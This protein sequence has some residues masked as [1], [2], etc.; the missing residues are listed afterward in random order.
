MPI[1][2]LKDILESHNLEQEKIFARF[3]NSVLGI[4]MM[5]FVRKYL[6]TQTSKPQVDDFIRQS[7]VQL[8]LYGISDSFKSKL[9]NLATLICK[10]NITLCCVWPGLE[11]MKSSRPNIQTEIQQITDF[12][13]FEKN[14]RWAVSMD[15]L[16]QQ[17]DAL[18]M[19]Y[20]SSESGKEDATKSNNEKIQ[21]IRAPYTA[22]AQLAYLKFSNVIDHVFSSSDFLLFGDEVITNLDVI[23]ETLVDRSS[24]KIFIKNDNDLRKVVD[25]MQSKNDGSSPITFISRD[26]IMSKLEIDLASLRILFLCLGCEYLPTLPLFSSDFSS[27]KIIN[28]L[29]DSEFSLEK[30]RNSMD[31]HYSKNSNLVSQYI[32]DL[33]AGIVYTAM[34]PVMGVDGKL[35]VYLISEKFDDSSKKNKK[36]VKMEIENLPEDFGSIFGQRKS[37]IWYEELFAERITPLV[38]EAALKKKFTPALCKV[39]GGQEEITKTPEKDKKKS[40]QENNSNQKKADGTYQD[41]QVESEQKKSDKKKLDRILPITTVK[42]NSEDISTSSSTESA[43][44]KP[45]ESEIISKNK[46][47]LLIRCARKKFFR[48]DVIVKLLLLYENLKYDSIRE[49]CPIRTNIKEH[50]FDEA[51]NLLNAPYEKL[52]DEKECF[53]FIMNEK[54]KLLKH[55]SVLLRLTNKIGPHIQHDSNYFVTIPLQNI[56]YATRI[57]RDHKIVEYFR[58][59]LRVLDGRGLSLDELEKRLKR[60]TT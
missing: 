47:K 26:N 31:L 52:F 35:G 48:G 29:K 5:W 3:A 37:D 4:D 10:H 46:Q 15:H 43:H 21:I 50:E 25:L 1:R 59:V 12:N 42:F 57:G 33:K 2:G 45:I 53:D 6:L 19:Y 39:T 30:L 24:E 9:K 28:F 56:I 16:M 7:M 36:L 17:I 20:I 49:D 60:I 11:A 23:E 27:L 44:I 55:Y 40:N 8:M 38:C 51:V 14:C 54:G 58:E 13:L 34:H 18:L 32:T 22:Q 41:K